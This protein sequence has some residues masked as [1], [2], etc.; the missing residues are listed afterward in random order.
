MGPVNIKSITEALRLVL[1]ALY[2]N[3]LDPYTI[4][5]Q[6]VVL[7]VLMRGNV[8][9]FPVQNYQTVSV[10]EIIPSNKFHQTAS[11]H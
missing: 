1:I 9:T 6:T 3:P 7:V 10:N 4:A 8:F 11:S 2:A 5:D